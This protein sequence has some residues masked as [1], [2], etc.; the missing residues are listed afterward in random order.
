MIIQQERNEATTA[1]DDQLMVAVVK[2]QGGPE[3]PLVFEAS[4]Q[5]EFHDSS[6]LLRRV[7]QE[8]PQAQ[9]EAIHFAS[10]GISWRE[11]A[12][13]K[14]SVGTEATRQLLA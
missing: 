4:N 13:K 10:K 5:L 3:S 14:M 1:S 8:L 9:K 6:D 2:R 7:L 12:A 11:I